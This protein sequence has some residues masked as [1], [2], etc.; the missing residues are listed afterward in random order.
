[1]THE[2]GTWYPIEMRNVGLCDSDTGQSLV[3]IKEVNV[4]DLQSWSDEAWLVYTEAKRGR[5]VQLQSGSVHIH[6]FYDEPASQRMIEEDGSRRGFPNM[7]AVV[8]ENAPPA[9]VEKEDG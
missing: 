9:S 3:A 4:S 8:L 6:Y 5:I 1:M 7:L 2:V